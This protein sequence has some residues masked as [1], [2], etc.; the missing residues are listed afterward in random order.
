MATLPIINVQLN[1]LDALLS[2][3]GIRLGQLANS[4]NQA[5][6]SLIDDKD[7]II[8][9]TSDDG[10]MRYFVINNNQITRHQGYATNP[11]LTIHFKDSWQGAKLLTQDE[12][13]LMAAAKDKQIQINGGYLLVFWFSQLSKQAT[14]LPD[15][16][17]PYVNQA[18]PYFN[19]AKPYINKAQPY[20]KKLAQF[21]D[22]KISN[23]PNNKT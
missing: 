14:S 15:K 12:L 13:A 16:Y 20:A 22:K 9:F 2:L 17:Q 18:K 4:D 8:Q 5:F 21:L 23:K 6:I 7:E 1:P 11:S 19:K 3:I 10:V